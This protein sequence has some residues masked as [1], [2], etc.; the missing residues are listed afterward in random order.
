M[1]HPNVEHAITMLRKVEEGIT[2]E[3]CP[4][5]RNQL[6]WK[7]DPRSWS[8]AECLDHVMVTNKSYFKR[9]DQVK[10]HAIQTSFLGKIP[11]WAN[12]CSNA[13]LKTVDPKSK[14][15]TKTPKAFKP[16]RSDYPI[17]IV[18]QYLDVHH[19]LVAYLNELDGF[20]AHEQIVFASPISNLFQLR[21]D[22]VIEILWKHSVRH[23]HQA[24]RVIAN[25]DF[26]S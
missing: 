13:I 16:E 1:N 20:E 5:S 9:F 17:H 21:L 18:D 12:F 15:K 3:I 4:L 26:P 22:K 24:R 6:N 19:E 25:N 8:V 7:P 23:L 11:G 2:Q 10:N 14:G